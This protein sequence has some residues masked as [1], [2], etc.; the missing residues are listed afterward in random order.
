[1]VFLQSRRGSAKLGGVEQG[2]FVG[3]KPS[4]K[5]KLKAADRRRKRRPMTSDAPQGMSP[6]TASNPPSNQSNRSGGNRR[7]DSTDLIV[8]TI[9]HHVSERQRSAQDAFVIST[10]RSVLRGTPA[11][12]D[13]ASELRNRLDE[14]PSREDVDRRSYREGIKTILGIAQ[15][16][17]N[18]AVPDAFL[19]YLSILST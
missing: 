7:V 16:Q 4:L 13:E 19:Q 3:K 18:Q 8:S 12:S 2:D 6:R 11:G 5:A 1:M 9:L 14:I 10:L 15:Q 17:E